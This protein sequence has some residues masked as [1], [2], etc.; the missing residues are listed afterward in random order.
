MYNFQFS[1]LFQAQTCCCR[2]TTLT[3]LHFSICC[4]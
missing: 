2:C 4:V 3:S 1:K